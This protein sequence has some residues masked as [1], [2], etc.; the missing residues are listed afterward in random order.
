MRT[1]GVEDVVQRIEPFARVNFGSYLEREFTVAMK[2]THSPK[3]KPVHRKNEV[4]PVEPVVDLLP[5]EDQIADDQFAVAGREEEAS[6]SGHRVEPIIDD[7]EGNA[8]RLIEDGL[9]G[10]LHAIPKKPR[11]R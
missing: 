1:R 10:Y 11:N 8:E 7:E 5:D 4:E 3:T 2:K 9:H 6:S